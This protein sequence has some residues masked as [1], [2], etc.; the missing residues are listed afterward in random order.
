LSNKGWQSQRFYLHNDD[1]RFPAFTHRVILGAQEQ[2]RWVLPRELQTH[3][4][5]L[6]D[7]LRRLRDRGLTAA[8]VIAAFHRQRF[9]PLTER[10]LRLD[11]M[12]PEASVESSWMASA[13]LPT[14]ELLQRVKGMVRKVDYSIVV[15]MRPNQGCVPGESSIFN[16]VACFS[17]LVLL[18]V[19]L[20]RGCEAFRQPN[21]WFRKTQPTGRRVG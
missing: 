11:K 19:S 14:D 18:L 1:E 15:S 6:L 9:L 3:L 4:K 16:S 13:T 12:T 2:W 20:C 10:R 8:G 7:A 21:P 5:P 17:L